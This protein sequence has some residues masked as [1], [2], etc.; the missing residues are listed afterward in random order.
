MVYSIKLLGSLKVVTYAVAGK[1]E[2]DLRQSLQVNAFP[3][4]NDPIGLYNARTDWTLSAQWFVLPTARGCQVDS[5]T[6]TLAM[7]MTLP[8]LSSTAGISPDVLNRW[9]TFISNTI[10]HESGHVTRNYQGASGFQHEL[11]NALPA[12]DCATLKQELS[13][14]FTRATDVI[15][16]TNIDYDAN[17]QHGAKQGAVF[18]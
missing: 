2:N 17:T 15:K 18:Q 9:T 11:G 13:G 16:Q 3:D 8:A 5:G 6:A 12:A 4:A 14:M 7:T 1:T 10:T